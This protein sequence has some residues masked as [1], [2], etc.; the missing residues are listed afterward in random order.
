[1]TLDVAICTYGPRGLAKV[2]SMLLPEEDGV[3]YVVS[4]QEHG[5]APVPHGLIRRKDVE[6]HRL[7][8]S[9]LSNNRNNALSHCRGDIVLIADD[10][11]VYAVGAFRKIRE[12]FMA[13]PGVD[14]ITFRVLFPN[15]KSYPPDGAVLDSPLPKGYWIS[16]IEMALRRSSLGGL[17]FSPLLGLGAPEMHCGEEELFFVEAVKG[18]LKARHSSIEICSHPSDTTGGGVTPGIL[19]GQG[20]VMRVVYPRSVWAR[21]VLKAWRLSRGG[22]CGFLEALSHLLRGAFRTKSVMR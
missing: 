20:C 5:G 7:E 11:L 21:I 16:S 18:G 19:K 10:D 8:E 3:R 4:W 13:A 6:V 1:M 12:S 2:E 22:R 15:P 17:R 14:I 9:G